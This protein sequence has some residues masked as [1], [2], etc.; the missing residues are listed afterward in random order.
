MWFI[1]YA[2]GNIDPYFFKHEDEAHL[3]ANSGLYLDLEEITFPDDGAS[4][5]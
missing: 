4:N 5:N 3:T 1:L 2:G